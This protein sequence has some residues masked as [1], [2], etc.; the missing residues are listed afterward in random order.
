LYGAE[1]GAKVKQA[2]LFEL[3]EY[4]QS[5]GRLGSAGASPGLSEEELRRLFPFISAAVR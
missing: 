5:G 3:C 2:E 4:G 1:T